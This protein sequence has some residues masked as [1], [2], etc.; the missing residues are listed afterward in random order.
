MLKRLGA[1]VKGRGEEVPFVFEVLVQGVAP[2]PQLGSKP[3]RLA[4]RWKRGKKEGTTQARWPLPSE[5]E[6]SAPPLLPLT[7][8]F[9]E[10]ISVPATLY[11]ARAGV[12]RS[13][14]SN[15]DQRPLQLPPGKAP[16]GPPAFA[17]KDLVFTLVE[18]DSSGKAVDAGTLTL[19]LALFASADSERQIPNGLL[20]LATAVTQGAPAAPP[21]LRHS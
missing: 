18:V 10:R 4:L 21:A 7:Y 2:W 19:N 15:A 13:A 5:G 3:K 20:T 1:A 17:A 11:K 12:Q 8:Q 16:R 14:R 6:G 9:D